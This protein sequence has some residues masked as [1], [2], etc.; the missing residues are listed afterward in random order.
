MIQFSANV[1]DLS[2]IEL[3]ESIA[4]IRD[5]NIAATAKRE[6]CDPQI[7]S[8]IHNKKFPLYEY[9]RIQYSLDK[10]NEFNKSPS[11]IL[12]VGPGKC[13][14]TRAL[15]KRF[16]NT[17]LTLLDIIDLQNKPF[18]KS[19]DQLTLHQG[20]IDETPFSDKQY[21]LTIC[22]EVLEHLP[23]NLLVSAIQEIRRVSKDYILSVP[24][25]EN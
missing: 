19:I 22:T 17:S 1:I 12:E 23:T 4:E 3:A 25:L 18:L 16:P 24:F 14:L 15:S 8:S 11:S 6:E 7:A 10:A 13:I 20:S 9:Q 2:S 21:D 5:K